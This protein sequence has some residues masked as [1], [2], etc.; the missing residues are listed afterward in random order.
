[1]LRLIAR[2]NVGG[3]AVLESRLAEDL[4]PAEFPSWLLAGSVEAGEADYLQLRAGNV[5][6][7]H[8]P[9]L[10]RSPSLTGDTR[11][12]REIVRQIRR[13]Q[14]DIVHTHTAKA[15]A[16]GRVAA[17]WCG[18][19]YTVHTFHGHLLHGYFSPGVTAAVRV[20]ERSLAHHTTRL[21][22]VGAKVRDDL[23]RAGIG[24]P[25]QY[26][27]MPPGVSL[28][29]P[30][31]RAEARRSLGISPEQPVLAFVARLTAIKAPF[32]MV[33]VVARLVREFPDLVV[34]V[35]GEGPILQQVRQAASSLG[36]TIQFLG[37]RSDVEAI[38]A[39]ADAALLTSDN[40][41]M[42]ISLI[43]AALCG[44]PAIATDV[45]SVS[46]VVVDGV[47]G[48]LATTDAAS[49]TAAATT[50][51]QQED[52]RRTFGEAAA[53]RA[54]RLFSAERLVADTAALYRSLVH[55]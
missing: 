37:W 54:R 3:P 26:V 19:P 14:P 15:G 16:L 11:A 8:V 35:A 27:V 53:E 44:V 33:E 17:R 5:P 29:P 36:G 24:R 31:S 34:L 18:I 47:T 43:E 25:D 20:V 51:L 32:R 12:M 50:L 6:V 55:G 48:L 22:T 46:E 52:M 4:D 21:A 7:I 45:G 39:A 49:L 38:Y 42:P 28:P 9:G 30:P 10:G 23:L 2:L 13:L 40:E 1:M 41:G